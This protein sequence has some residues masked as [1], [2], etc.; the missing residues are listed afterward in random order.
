MCGITDPGGCVADAARSGLEAMAEAI[1]D[2]AAW[3]ITES[4][5]WWV[6]TSA[7]QLNTG[8]VNAVREVTMPLTV[9][10]AA[11]GMIV[12]G[13]RMVLSGS[14]DPLLSMG[15]GV[16]KLT[17]WTVA[18]TLVLNSAM[19]AAAAF[20]GWVLD[21][22]RTRKLGEQLV[23]AFDLPVEDNIGVILLL[24]LIGFLAGVVQWL[25]SLFREG[26]VVILAGC[27][28]LAASGS[29]GLGRPWLSKITGWCLALIFWQPA[30][31][32][33]YFAAF[34]MLEH[35]RGGQETLVG[36]TM[37]VIA[38]FAL[39]TLMKLFSWVV[40]TSSGGG[41]SGSSKA[42]GVAMAYQI[43][44]AAAVRGSGRMSP[45][46]HARLIGSALPH[47]GTPGGGQT[48]PGSVASGAV[49]GS[50]TP[51]ADPAGP[52]GPAWTPGTISGTPGAPGTSGGGAAG[53]SGATGAGGAA[54]SGAGAA[55]PAAGEASA[56]AAGA[57]G[58]KATAAAGPIGAAAAA[59][60][61][62]AAGAKAVGRAM[63]EGADAQPASPRE[64]GKEGSK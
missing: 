62:G 43:R 52:G 37:L 2:A 45:D 64:P 44:G 31:S 6:D 10:V 42:A 27:L 40:S 30:A 38:N 18:G 33:V 25:I 9:S 53:G 1:A 50:R 57:V 11:A 3:I 35:A 22:A 7:D 63:T 39:P 49:P 21:S 4:F 12:F 20:S 61:V 16:A 48:G 51:A 13:I 41:G 55:A 24:S 58:A 5:T 54:A 28:P 19:K 29:L 56:G 59:A 34:S 47:Q 60:V 23:E 46:Q 17:F 15:E 36:I 32:L 26:A 8:V 14:P